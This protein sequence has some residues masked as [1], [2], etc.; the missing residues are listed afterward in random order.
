MS[1]DVEHLTTAAARETWWSTQGDSWPYP[2]HAALMPREGV[3]PSDAMWLAQGFREAVSRVHDYGLD[4]P[5]HWSLA[6]NRRLADEGNAE[7]R[8]VLDRNPPHRAS[9]DPDYDCPH[10][11]CQ[12]MWPM[13]RAAEARAHLAEVAS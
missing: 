7:A 5:E 10:S 2:T 9:E 12:R 6:I 11:W 8:A 13:V 1:R 3:E 4:E